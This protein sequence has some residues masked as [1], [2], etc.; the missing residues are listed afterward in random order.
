M[1]E[2]DV[3]ER[4]KVLTFTE[5]KNKDLTESAIALTVT[6]DSSARDGTALRVPLAVTGENWITWEQQII[7]ILGS[8][9]CL[10]DERVPVQQPVKKAFE[11]ISII[12]KNLALPLLVKVRPH[13]GNPL[14]MWNFLKSEFAGINKQRRSARIQ[15]LM[16]QWINPKA[17]TEGV[18]T[19]VSQIESLT[20]SNG[21]DQLSIQALGITAILSALPFELSYL[22]ADLESAGPDLWK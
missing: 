8:K 19:M 7:P 18:Q 3:S 9:E 2:Q 1:S 10:T 4:L 22:K 6:A 15:A 13:L 12:Q 14:H 20:E 17:F 16:K 11:A 21:S 5:L